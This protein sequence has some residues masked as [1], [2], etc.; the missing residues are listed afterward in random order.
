MRWYEVFWVWAAV[1]LA[2][3]SGV[4]AILA[5]LGVV[6]LPVFLLVVGPALSWMVL[7]ALPLVI[8]AR[9][10]RSLGGEREAILEEAESLSA[11]LVSDLPYRFGLGPEDDG[12]GALVLSS[13]EEKTLVYRALLRIIHTLGVEV[14]H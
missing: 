10:R 6:D 2:F 12:A 3:G 11:E 5:G 1:L 7:G 14:D 9:R 8:G 4:V 13:S